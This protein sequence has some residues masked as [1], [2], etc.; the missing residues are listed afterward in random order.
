[1]R[2]WYSGS[3]TLLQDFLPC[4][5][6]P[7]RNW[8]FNSMPNRSFCSLWCCFMSDI[9]YEELIPFSIFCCT[10]LQVQMSDITYE[11]LIRCR[12]RC[13]SQYPNR[14]TLP[15]RNWYDSDVDGVSTSSVSTSCRTLPMRNWYVIYT[16]NSFSPRR[17]CRTLPMRNWYDD[18]KINAAVFHSIPINVGHYLWGIDTRRLV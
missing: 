12:C 8:Y 4:R 9:T 2:N 5:T 1:M 6:L 7:M 17:I 18:G 3:L 11:E 15:M 13:F 14:R 16:T 10:C